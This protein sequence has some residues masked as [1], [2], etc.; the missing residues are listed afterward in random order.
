MSDP[1]LYENA[2]VMA[3]LTVLERVVGLIVRDGMLKTGK[4]PED[5]LAFG[6]SVKKHF[7][8]RTPEGSTDAELNAAADRLFSSIA[9][10]IGSQDSQ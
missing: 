10:D 8:G 1:T 3:R 7:E 5:I 6:E 2:Q 9:S 4:G